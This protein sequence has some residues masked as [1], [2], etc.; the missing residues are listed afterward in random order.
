MYGHFKFSVAENEKLYIVL[1]SWVYN[2]FFTINKIKYV[3]KKWVGLYSRYCDSLGV[4]RSGDSIPVGA[5]F[6]APVQNGPGAHPAS[7]TTGT[8]FL[9]GVNRPGS[10]VDHQPPSIVEVTL[11]LGFHGLLEGEIPLHFMPL[12]N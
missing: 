5:R 8:G 9:P 1:Y 3:T 4:G 2:L 11:P 6:S 10:S 12:R 7:Y